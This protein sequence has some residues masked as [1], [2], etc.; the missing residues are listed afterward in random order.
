MSWCLIPKHANQFLK[1]LRAGEISPEKLNNMSSAERNKFFADKFGDDNAK[2]INALFESKLLLKNKEKGMITWA[3]K[4]AGITP[5]V[6]RDMIS[7][8]E[9][10]DNILSETDEKKFLADLASKKIGVDISVVEAKKIT[11]FSKKIHDLSLDVSTKDKR[12]AYGNA[13]LDMQ[14]YLDQISKKKMGLVGNIV[15]ITNVP[16]AAMSTLDFSAPLRQGWGMLSRPKQFIPAFKDMFRYAFSENSYKNLMADI[17][18]RPNY[19]L[20]K[21]SGLRITSLLSNKLTMRE[22]EFMTTLLDRIPGVR[23]SER[24]YSGFLTRLRADVFDSLIQQ[25]QMKGEDVSKGSQTVKDI[26]SVV[27]NF[28][29]S[30]N[31]GKNDR[32]AAA[33][34]LLNSLFFSP[35]KIAATVNMFNPVVYGGLTPTA[36]R[37][38]FRN[39]IGSVGITATILFLAGLAGAD[40]EKDPISSDFGKIKVGDTR[41]DVT[42]GNGNYL[43]LLARIL[44]GKTKST[45]TELSRELA[46]GFGSTTRGDLLVKYIRNKLSPT[47][48]FIADWLYGTDAIGTPFKVKDAI[49]NRIMPMTISGFIDAVNVDPK[50]AVMATLLGLFGVG[51]QTYSTAVDWSTSTGKELMQFK[52]KIGDDKFTEANKKYN[53]LYKTKFDALKVNPTYQKLSNEEKQVVI[54]DLKK[55]IKDIIFKNYRFKY[56]QETKT[57]A[58]KSADKQLQNLS[59]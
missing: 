15:N 42:G 44:T 52:A 32:F 1:E 50:N 24:A 58:Q 4:V 20:M 57:S 35:R 28:T 51:V 39:L 46:S 31:L 5:D 2:N 37:A 40:W 36:R 19:D 10:M 11:D 16:R 49:V 33:V 34:P 55:N 18:T 56:K 17:I 22:E 9:K 14:E 26:A 48:S 7:K 27:N 53:D 45:T 21:S 30:G 38:A 41:L 23:G 13:I 3:K 59:K 12:I 43:V 25:A 29:G 47:A 54:T 6:R 8:I